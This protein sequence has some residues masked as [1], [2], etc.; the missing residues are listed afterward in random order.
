[1]TSATSLKET[2]TAAT[3]MTRSWFSSTMMEDAYLQQDP[4]A[5]CTFSTV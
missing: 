2:L 4:L 3:C 1:M 5:K